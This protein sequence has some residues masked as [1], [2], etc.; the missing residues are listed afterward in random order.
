LPTCRPDWCRHQTMDFFGNSIHRKN[1][2]LRQHPTFFPNKVKRLLGCGWG[3]V[4]CSVIGAPPLALW[5]G[6][7]PLLCSWGTVPYSV[8]GAQSPALWLRRRLFGGISCQTFR[9]GLELSLSPFT[10]LT[11]LRVATTRVS[12]RGTSLPTG[13]HP[14]QPGHILANRSTSLPTGLPPCQ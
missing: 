12:N 9:A 7:R 1:L 8:V 10:P 2:A 6:H 3:T 11:S 14:C 13:P 4:P 5:L